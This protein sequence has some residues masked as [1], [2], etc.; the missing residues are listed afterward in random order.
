MLDWKNGQPFSDRFGDVYFSADSVLEETRHVFPQGNRL[1]DRFAAL[2]GAKL[3]HRRDRLS[4]RAELSL[5]MAIVRASRASGRE[6]G[7]FQRR[8]ISPE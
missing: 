7:F 1:E 6:P 2:N 5:C 3:L 8:E 4:H